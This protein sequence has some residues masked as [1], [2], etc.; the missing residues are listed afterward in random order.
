MRAILKEVG[1]N[2]KIIEIE[3]TLEALQQAVG[4]Y[5]QAVYLDENIVL[6]CDEEGK[7]KGKEYNFA[8]PTDIIVGDVLFLCTSDEDFTGITEE[9]E[10]TIM[11]LFAK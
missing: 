4:G 10:K 1:Q 2:P 7:L 6:L 8:L 11:S 5:I 9:A 3:N